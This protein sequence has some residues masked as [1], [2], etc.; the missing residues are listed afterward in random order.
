MSTTKKTDIINSLLDLPEFEPETSA[1]KLPRLGIVL[2]LRELP[3]DKLV[4]LSR[5][6]DAQIHLILSC[7]TNHPELKQAEW[8]K[9]KMKCATPADGLKRLLRKGEVEKICR[10]IDLLHGYSVGQCGPP[11]GGPADGGGHPRRRGGPGK[12]LTRRADLAAAQRLLVEHG[13]FPGDFL[14]RPPGEP[15]RWCARC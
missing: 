6:Q 4:R 5:E 15:G 8:Y 10:T 11:A 1:V 2:E 12:K 13:V 9:E 3:Y 14:R 7:V